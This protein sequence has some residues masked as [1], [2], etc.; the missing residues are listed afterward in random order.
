MQFVLLTLACIIAYIGGL[1]VL[2]RMTPMLIGRSYDEGLFMGIAAAILIGAFLAFGAVA[3]TFITFNGH[4]VV[5]VLDFLFL[6][7]I[8][9]VALR[10]SL[11]SLRS[12]GFSGTFLISRMIVGIYCLF[13]GIGSLYYMVQLFV[14]K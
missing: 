8:L 11:T 10:L 13:L 6:L 1:F 12:S 14:T 5:R 2:V 4:I 3:I 9:V 7:G